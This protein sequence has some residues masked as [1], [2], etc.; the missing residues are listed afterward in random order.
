MP[1]WLTVVKDLAPPLGTVIAIVALLYQIS[2]SR[3]LTGIDVLHKVA[4][5]WDDMRSERCDA[6]S[7]IKDRADRNLPL[8]QGL[9]D[10][11]EVLDFLD[12]IAYLV[13]QKAIP[14][15]SV[16]YAFFY[17]IDGYMRWCGPY[18]A[19]KNG[20]PWEDLRELYEELCAIQ[21][22]R[23]SKV[24][25]G[26]GASHSFLQEEIDRNCSDNAPSAC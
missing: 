10:T 16:W 2:R 12:Y 18:V 17:W 1:P 13:H 11:D 22:K 20:N 7:A 4:G 9:G 26:S 3:F 21:K 6:A 19:S 8:D 23:K 24:V 25:T 15:V 14:K 5:D